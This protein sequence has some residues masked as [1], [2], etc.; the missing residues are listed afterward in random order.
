MI[1]QNDLT[2]SQ[3][4]ALQNI[5]NYFE[6]AKSSTTRQQWR[7]NY[8][9]C[10]KYYHGNQWLNSALN[11]SMY[12]ISAIQR[13][14]NNI[15]PLVDNLSSLQIRSSKRVGYKADIDFPIYTKMAENLKHL[16]YSIQTHSEHTYNA[17]KKIEN[18]LIGGIGWSLF[19]YDKEEQQFKYKSINPLNVLWDPD[20]DS[21]RINNSN[22]VCHV[23]YM[24]VV[25]LKQIYPKKTKLFDSLIDINTVTSSYTYDNEID[26]V[27]D[28]LIKGRKIKVI[29]VY[30]KKNAK[31]YE[32][33]VELTTDEE[34][35]AGET[36]I[37][38]FSTFNEEFAKENSY[39]NNVEE[40]EG[41]QIWKGV[42]IDNYLLEHEPINYQVP[43]QK[44]FPLIPV[45]L[46]RNHMC[47]PQG[48]VSNLIPIQ[49]TH[50][51]LW[52]STLHYMD[53][54]TIILSDAVVDKDKLRNEIKT[55]MRAKNGVVF[56]HNAKEMQLI[57][58]NS[59]LNYRMHLIQNN[60]REF[61]TQTGLYD[62]LKGNETNA[63]SGIAI[64][65]RAI[66][67][68]EA[69]NYL[70]LTYENMLVNEGKLLLD[71]IKGIG[72][73]TYNLKYYNSGKTVTADFGNNISLMDF[74]VYPEVA[75]NFSSG[76]EEEQA[77]FAE[78]INNP[79][80]NLMLMS[81]LMMQMLGISEQ[82]AFEL[83]EE[84]KKILNGP[85]QNNEEGNNE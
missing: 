45:V 82:K 71:T 27:D 42:Y 43:N 21:Q 55:E 4:L 34:D 30:Y 20:D 18:M 76:I 49:D 78:L 12:E 38:T 39:D 41:T 61:E 46:K 85:Q 16:A 36:I 69:Q 56:T 66:N 9:T 24:S 29:E 57:E 25:Q 77:R 28:S 48:I 15:K 67:A 19:N 83:T 68:Q 1:M 8:L 47:E 53:A 84:Y 6:Y 72:K 10:L 2:I 5:Q 81:P 52:S 75:P 62:E 22:F 17:S 70:M 23:S 13:T 11:A 80:A 7:E 3:K 51:F 31:Y 37:T 26:I 44:H 32:T 59:N 35:K 40:K 63:V 50:N 79:S 60:Y 58:H 73:F 64:K 54:K 74:N 33:K 14:Y 65:Q